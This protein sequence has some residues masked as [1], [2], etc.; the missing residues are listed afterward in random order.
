M[1]QY[2]VAIAGVGSRGAGTYAPYQKKYPDRMKIVAAADIKKDRLD[3]F[4][5]EYQFSGRDAQTGYIGRR[6]GHFHA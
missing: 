6:D 5:K 1:K 3:L 4:R 2:T